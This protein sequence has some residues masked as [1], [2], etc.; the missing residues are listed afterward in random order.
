[1]SETTV[2]RYPLSW[3]LADYLRGGAGLALTGGPLLLLDAVPVF[4]VILSCLSA[5]FAFFLARIA[6]RH[7]TIYRRDA[8]GLS[9]I[10]PWGRERRL[11][12][13]GLGALDLRY[14]ST[15]R[16]R[17]NGWMQLTLK[18]TD[19]TAFRLESPLTGFGDLLDSA[20]SAARGAG[21]SL[22]QTTIDNLAA[23]GYRLSGK[24]ENTL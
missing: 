7:G 3:L 19:G 23:S 10:D 12:W 15:Q 21:L 16:N 8:T 1:M 11:D 22:G 17:E 9:R 6:L 5:L 4:V 2:H 18:G 13:A 24:T 20:F 14:Y